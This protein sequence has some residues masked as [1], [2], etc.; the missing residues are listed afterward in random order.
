MPDKRRTEFEHLIRGPFGFVEKREMSF[1]GVRL[2]SSQ[3]PRDAALIARYVGEDWRF[4]VAWS[5]PQLSLLILVRYVRQQWPN[6]LRHVLFESFIE[7]STGGREMPVVPVITQRMSVSSVEA[8]MILRRE[9]FAAGLHPVVSAL[10]G[11]M[12]RY[13]EL[14]RSASLVQVSGYHAWMASL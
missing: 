6:D 10:A 3:D 2:A 7:Y 4:D 5:S 12:Q 1:R 13:M 11:R 14:V 9:R 8:A